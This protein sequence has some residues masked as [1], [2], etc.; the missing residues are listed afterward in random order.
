MTGVHTVVA[1]EYARGPLHTFLAAEINLGSY[2]VLAVSPGDTVY[3]PHFLDNLPRD[4]AEDRGHLL[5]Y[6]VVEPSPHDVLVELR[7]SSGEQDHL[8]ARDFVRY[9]VHEDLESIKHQGKFLRL[10]PLIVLPGA[11][12]IFARIGAESG[13]NRL[14]EPL[15]TY[16]R[17]TR[18]MEVHIVQW[19]TP[20]PPFMDIDSPDAY[21]ALEDYP[22]ERER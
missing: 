17:A 1:D 19:D 21:D 18:N 4:L 11:F 13:Q 14:E 2:P 9:P 3:H 12:F 16:T 7:A 6:P 22:M 20:V 5:C 10:A 8:V 15:A